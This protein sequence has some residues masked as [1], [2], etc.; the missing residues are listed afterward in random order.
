MGHGVEGEGA[1]PTPA[2]PAEPL[3]VKLGIR[4]QR[5]VERRDLVAQLHRSEVMIGRLGEIAAS[6]PHATV[7]HMQHG[8]ATLHQH[9][10]EETISGRPFSGDHLR[11]R[12]AIR[13]HNQRHACRRCLARRQHQLA[14]QRGGAIG[15]LPFDGRAAALIPHRAAALSRSS[16]SRSAWR[17]RSTTGGVVVEEIDVGKEVGVGREDRLVPFSGAAHLVLALSVQARPPR[18]AAGAGPPRW[19]GSRPCRATWFTPT[20]SPTS[21]LPP[22]SCLTRLASAANGFAPSKP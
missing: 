14:I 21:Q 11:V 12:A 10:I 1:A 7:V 15:S 6:A 5:L 18:S 3:G 22:V 4:A 8:E 2:P 9:L 20:I 19:R 16:G 13:I 17:H